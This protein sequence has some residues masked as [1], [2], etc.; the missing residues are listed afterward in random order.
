MEEIMN[1]LGYQKSLESTINYKMM[2]RDLI[3]NDPIYMTMVFCELLVDSLRPVGQAEV[4]YEGS[5]SI[6]H[7]KG[8]FNTIDVDYAMCRAL[9]IAVQTGTTSGG[10]I[11]MDTLINQLIATTRA[12][13]CTCMNLL[14]NYIKNPML[15]NGFFKVLTIVPG[16]FQIHLA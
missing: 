14:F 1:D 7:V 2:I 9:A 16:E 4:E 3:F 10:G 15:F 5:T 12:D 13:T 8:P 11:F 6:L